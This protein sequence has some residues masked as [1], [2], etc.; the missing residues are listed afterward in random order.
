MG[1]SFKSQALE[2]NLAQTR[3]KDIFIPEE[4]KAFIALSASYF[5]INKRASECITEYHHPLSNHTFV[6]EEL[7]KILMDDFWFYTRDDVSADTLTIPL[8]MMRNLLKP[9]VALKLRLNIVITLMEFANQVYTKSPKHSNLIELTFNILDDKFES[10]KDCYILATK[11]AE[12]YLENVAK[13]QNFNALACNLLRRML[14]ENYFYWQ[15]TSEVEQW[16]ADNASLLSDEEKNIIVNEV[17]KPYFDGINKD[18]DAADSWAQID[19][20]I[21]RCAEGK[22]LCNH[23]ITRPYAQ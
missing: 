7:R 16:V 13:D 18:L 10:N 14:K 5:G 23:L 17:G 22:T 19:N 21:R 4:H 9:E 12:R 15:T 2:A 3:Y 11:H 1:E 8:E 20:R 6:T